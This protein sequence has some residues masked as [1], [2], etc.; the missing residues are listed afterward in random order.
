M[1][2]VIRIVEPILAEIGLQL[3]EQVNAVNNYQSFTAIVSGEPINYK[4]LS[5]G[6]WRQ[7]KRTAVPYAMHKT[8]KLIISNF[9]RK[10][11][12]PQHELSEFLSLHYR[13]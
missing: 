9:K 2:R 13:K 1:D 6:R 11:A 12:I 10:R 8:L 5:G 4:R 3:V 7:E